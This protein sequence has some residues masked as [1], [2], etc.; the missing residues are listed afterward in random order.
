MEKINEEKKA[1]EV[2]KT[3]EEDKAGI[4]WKVR[5]KN[6]VFWFNV[7]I[8]VCVPVL[9]Y[10]GLTVEDMTSW[11]KVGEVIVAAFQNPFVIGT[12]A[13]GLWNAINDPTTA[14]VTDSRRAMYYEE[15]K[16]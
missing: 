6:P 12:M 8:A 13:V 2:A 4:N 15:P 7:L 14:G 3:K 1:V 10:Y 16:K 5:I 11:E 9:A